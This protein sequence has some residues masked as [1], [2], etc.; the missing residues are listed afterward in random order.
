MVTADHIEQ[1][2]AISN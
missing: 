1:V 2:T